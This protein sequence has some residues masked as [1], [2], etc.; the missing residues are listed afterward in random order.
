VKRLLALAIVLLV[1]ANTWAG[2]TRIASF[3]HRFRA[4]RALARADLDVALASL[5]SAAWWR[6]AD[7]STWLLMG[8]VVQQAQ[9]N[10]LPLKEMEGHGT[11]E[12]F[13]FGLEAV[14]HGIALNPA[15]AW[16]WFNVATLHQSFRKASE[17]LE[18]LRKAGEAALKQGAVPAPAPPQAERKGLDGVDRVSLA[19][20]RKAHQLEPEFPFYHD[21]LADLFWKRGMKEPAAEEI[22]AALALIPS[23][24]AHPILDNQSFLREMAGPILDGLEEASSSRYAER[25]LVLRARAEVLER[26]NRLDEAARTWES[27][28]DM[29]GRELR[30][31]SD[32]A[33]ARLLQER[34]QWKESLIPLKSA[35]DGGTDTVWGVQ[36]L[37]YTGIALARMGEHDR[38]RRALESYLVQ[39]PDSVAGY[40]ALA[41]E[42]AAL[43]KAAEAEKV[44][45]TAVRRFPTMPHLYE[46]VIAH[47]R[48]HGRSR[49][50]LLYAQALRKVGPDHDR[51][52]ALIA[53]IEAESR[54]QAP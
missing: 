13:G 50:A 34:D 10:G 42:L 23:V 47:L 22:R 26:L 38:A 1:A 7:S 31:E 40:D 4:E 46:N 29:E 30:Q 52:D 24:P 18:R 41:V 12:V 37:Y 33:I 17:R 15:D 20:V 16:G 32:V 5:R 36:S 27:L 6:P 11:L 8:Q 45:V 25:V 3:R 28:R 35:A 51:A 14:T 2:I 21:F 9:A 54:G 19:G 49:E 43:G 48:S 39:S 53:E 44:L